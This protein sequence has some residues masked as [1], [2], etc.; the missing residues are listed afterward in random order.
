M[1]G[2][3]LWEVFPYETRAL[4]ECPYRICPLYKTLIKRHPLGEV[5]GSLVR[6]EVHLFKEH[7][8]Q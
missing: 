6:P 1:G 5:K 3:P 7:V 2:I 4:R 8:L